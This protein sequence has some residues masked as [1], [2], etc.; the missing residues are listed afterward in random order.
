MQHSAK[1][2][3]WWSIAN[4]LVILYAV[5]PLL[6]I[7]SLSFKSQATVLDGNFIPQE[8]T[9]EN[10]KGIFKTSAFTS[11]LINSIGIGLI[12]SLIHI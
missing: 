3:A 5:I 12:L 9:L 11:A 4:I 1:S 8:W 2:K 7:I 10:Y 6:W